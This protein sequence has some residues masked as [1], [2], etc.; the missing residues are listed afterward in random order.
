M[1]GT[2]V[3]SEI[4]RLNEAK[5]DIKSAIESKGIEVPDGESISLFANRVNEINVS[6]LGLSPDTI[7]AGNTVTIKQGNK[8]VHEIQGNLEVLATGNS[9]PAQATYNIMYWGRLGYT[10]INGTVDVDIAGTPK[11]LHIARLN[12]TSEIN[13]CGKNSVGVY[14]EA[15]GLT[16]K[17]KYPWITTNSV[18]CAFVVL[19]VKD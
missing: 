12:G 14:T 15:D 5:A 6:V 11:Y 4:N 16:R 19:G 3:Q 1:D 8:T 9:G 10:L 17:I 13:I 7:L 18:Y 2:S